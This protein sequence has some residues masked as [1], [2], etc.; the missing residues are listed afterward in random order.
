MNIYY[1]AIALA[2]I[3]VIL[4]LSSIISGYQV[5]RKFRG[6]DFSETPIISFLIDKTIPKENTSKY[7]RYSDYIYILD[8][9]KNLRDLYLYKIV[10]LL[11]GFIIS[12]AILITDVRT[13]WVEAFQPSSEVPIEIT[14]DDYKILSLD[15]DFSN[16]LTEKNRETLSS[17][18]NLLESAELQENYKSLP[19]DILLKYL[20]AIHKNL[21][22]TINFIDLLVAI[23]ID[24]AS[25]MFPSL[26]VKFLYKFLESN[27][28]L[29]FDDLETDISMMADSHIIDIIESLRRNSMFYSELI[30]G[31]YIIYLDSPKAAYDMVATRPEFPD[32]FKILIRDLNMTETMSADSVRTRIRANKMNTKNRIMDIM[33]RQT[34]KKIN[35]LNFL[36]LSGFILSCLRLLLGLITLAK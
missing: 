24:I 25:W 22:N 19:V 34:R 28:I 4:I 9:R 23:G 16:V 31:F 32:M 30:N 26:I 3:G 6:G 10:C 12:T 20:S 15:I 17:N 27:E 8:S 2:A 35:K 1:I 29:E 14:R 33:S 18:I 21:G 36:C 13:N 5:N 7:Q 11:I